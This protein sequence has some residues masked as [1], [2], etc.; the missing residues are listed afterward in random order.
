MPAFECLL[1]SKYPQV[2][3]YSFINPLGVFAFIIRAANEKSGKLIPLHLLFKK[4]HDAT[5]ISRGIQLREYK[6]VIG[7]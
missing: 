5:S 7:L 3:E 1:C 2:V 6:Y 4:R